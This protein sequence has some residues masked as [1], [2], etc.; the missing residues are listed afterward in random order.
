MGSVRIIS[1]QNL[2]HTLH[3]KKIQDFLFIYLNSKPQYINIEQ[4]QYINISACSVNVLKFKKR[5]ATI[6]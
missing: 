5:K 1:K 6:N 2:I 3:L 4:V